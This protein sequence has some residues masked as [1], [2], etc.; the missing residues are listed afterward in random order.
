MQ[1]TG[2]GPWRGK[3]PRVEEQLSPRS[4]ATED[5]V[6]PKP[7]STAR[8]AT[9][10][11]RCAPHLEM[12]QRRAHTAAKTQ[13]SQKQVNKH[14]AGTQASRPG[15][16]PGLSR[17]RGRRSGCLKARPTDPGV[18]HPSWHQDRTNPGGKQSRT[19][20][21]YVRAARG[22]ERAGR[23]QAR[24]RPGAGG[25]RS[26]P[27]GEAPGSGEMLLYSCPAKPDCLAQKTRLSPAAVLTTFTVFHMLAGQ[28][29]LMTSIQ[30]NF[31]VRQ[32]SE[33]LI[34]LLLI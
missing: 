34:L 11:R 22:G 5:Q 32:M 16:L 25:G 28:Q 9:S 3:I 17:S 27:R 15:G 31:L 29:A 8:E 20:T 26:R 1:G 7:C 2:L 21:L 13:L 19:H 18:T 33:N 4:T 12:P 6:P 10:L 23:G 30:T 24:G 14:E